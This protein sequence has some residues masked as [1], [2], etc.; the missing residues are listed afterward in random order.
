VFQSPFAIL[1]IFWCLDKHGQ[2]LCM[3]LAVIQQHISG[4]ISARLAYTLLALIPPLLLSL[5]P[6]QLTLPASLTARQR[7]LLHEFAEGAGLQHVSTG[8]GTSRRL[9]LGPSTA[10]HKVM[11]LAATPCMRG[12]P[13]ALSA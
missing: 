11:S 7:A 12:T 6:M 5:I 1:L 3:S 4:K 10:S 13:G 8:E 2:M 9:Q